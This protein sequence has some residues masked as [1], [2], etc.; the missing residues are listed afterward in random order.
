MKTLFN[1]GVFGII[2]NEK[3]E[4]LLCHRTDR[5]IWNLPGGDRLLILSLAHLY[6]DS[7]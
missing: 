4:I 3:K 1:I 5:D 7:L 6:L 2:L